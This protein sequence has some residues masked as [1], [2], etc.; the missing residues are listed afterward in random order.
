[1]H[2]NHGRRNS[3]KTLQTRQTRRIRLRKFTDFILEPLTCDTPACNY[4]RKAVV[5]IDF[6]SR[7]SRRMDLQ[8]LARHQ[9]PRLLPKRKKLATRTLNLLNRGLVLKSPIPLR[10]PLHWQCE[11]IFAQSSSA[12]CPPRSSTKAAL[13][14]KPECPIVKRK[15]RVPPSR[16]QCKRS[17]FEQVCASTRET[18]GTLLPPIS[19]IMGADLRTVQEL[20]GHSSIHR[21]QL[22]T[23]INKNVVQKAFDRYYPGRVSRAR[24]T[25]P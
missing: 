14:R 20:M 16:K 3:L 19:P 12:E 7:C 8:A 17:G 4:L 15:S 13:S 10:R 25:Q 6:V 9:G 2:E 22:Y 1:M 11:R 21:T 18:L 24:E 23:H 5:M